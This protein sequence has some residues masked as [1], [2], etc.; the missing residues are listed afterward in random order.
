[1]ANTMHQQADVRGASYFVADSR[2]TE[3]SN[4]NQ[5]AKTGRDYLIAA[6]PF[7]ARTAKPRLRPR[8]FDNALFQEDVP[9]ES[10]IT[11]LDNA[12]SGFRCCIEYKALQ[13]HYRQLV[14]RR[15]DGPADVPQHLWFVL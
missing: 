2:S 10:R 3:G 12:K 6:T 13:P 8:T 14:A 15:L 1:M 7:A 4:W 11:A 5:P 9:L